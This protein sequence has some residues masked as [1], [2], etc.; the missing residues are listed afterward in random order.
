MFTEYPSDWDTMSEKDEVK[1]YLVDPETERSEYD[2]VTAEF[3][4]TLPDVK[5]L[6]VQRVQNKTVWQ[7]YLHCVQML[8]EIDPPILGEK[9]LFHGTSQNDPKEIY[10]GAEGFDM[11]FSR[12]GAWG[13]GNYFAVNA[14]YSDRYAFHAGDGIKKMFAAWVLTGRAYLSKPKSSLTKPPFLNESDDGDGTAVR[15]RFDSVCGSTG[16]TRVYITYD[17]VHAYPAYLISYK[18]N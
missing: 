4:Q 13:R 12:D 17:N 6:K 10:Q 8:Q 11:R 3:M 18:K 9:L 2:R 7:K 15:H 14:S 16:G 5:I 1:L